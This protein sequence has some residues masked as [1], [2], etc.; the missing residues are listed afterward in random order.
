[1][2]LLFGP[3]G[4]KEAAKK[5]STMLRQ[6]IATFV[7][8]LIFISRLGVAAVGLSQRLWQSGG[9]ARENQ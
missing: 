2:Q 3:A 1:L 8:V 4:P 7:Q 9:S 5:K 6:A